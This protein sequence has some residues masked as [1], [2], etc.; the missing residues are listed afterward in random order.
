MS[1]YLTPHTSVSSRT[2]R[3]L[4]ESATTGTSGR[5]FEIMRAVYPDA[6]ITSTYAC[7]LKPQSTLKLHRF[8]AAKKSRD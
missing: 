2:V 1:K 4:G 3:R 8:L 7:T 6:V 5:Y